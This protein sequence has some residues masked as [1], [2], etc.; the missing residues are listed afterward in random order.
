MAPL[1]EAV[2]ESPFTVALMIRPETPRWT[3]VKALTVP[4]PSL[5]L[6]VTSA[7]EAVTVHVAFGFALV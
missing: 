6:R 3:F 7:A 5:S 1:I 2:P 4:M